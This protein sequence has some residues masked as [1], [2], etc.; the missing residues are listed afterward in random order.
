MSSGMIAPASV[1]QEMIA[2]NFHQR[3][4]GTP[5]PCTFSSRTFEARKVTPIERNDVTHTSCVRGC[6][7][8]IFFAPRVFALT[9]AS[10]KK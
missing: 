5:S 4:A 3:P 9:Y 7:K 10:F 6:S 8:S 2:D 1:P